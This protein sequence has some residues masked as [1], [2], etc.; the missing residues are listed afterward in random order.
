[1]D[2]GK[3][4]IVGICSTSEPNRRIWTRM[5]SLLGFFTH[6]P[7]HHPVTFS[8]SQFF[9]NR[10]ITQKEWF[11]L[12]QPR[13]MSSPSHFIRL[14]VNRWSERW[15]ATILSP[16]LPWLLS[17]EV[18]G[19]LLKVICISCIQKNRFMIQKYPYIHT[20]IINA[21]FYFVFKA[22]KVSQRSCKTT[23]STR[24]RLLG[25]Q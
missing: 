14:R 3:I 25:K 1:M 10:R 9:S 7:D 17:R 4:S 11:Q 15:R 5:W 23:S 13:M 20:Y 18:S 22:S 19:R 12:L 21:V 2:H 6:V 24:Q 8:L 16:C